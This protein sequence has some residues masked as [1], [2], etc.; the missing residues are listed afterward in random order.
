MSDSKSNEFDDILKYY[1]IVNV[2]IDKLF[3]EYILTPNA[4]ES[5]VTDK[6]K[7]KQFLNRF[8]NEICFAELVKNRIDKKRILTDKITEFSGISSDDLNKIITTSILPDKIPLKRMIK[9][10]TLLKIPIQQAISSFWISFKRFNNINLDLSRGF[11]SYKRNSLPKSDFIFYNNSKVLLMK[12]L[13]EYCN[14]LK[15]EEDK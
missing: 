5:P 2:E 7:S 15:A 11:A 3:V 10:L 14:R 1:S 9:L 4:I 13:A 8:S 12:N 6:E